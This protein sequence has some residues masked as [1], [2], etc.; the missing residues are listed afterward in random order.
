MI[1]ALSSLEADANKK[2]TKENKKK[3]QIYEN[4]LKQNVNE[5]QFLKYKTIQVYPDKNKR[6]PALS[7]LLEVS[8]KL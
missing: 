1:S 2:S 4:N 7:H 3:H 8:S 6:W 5:I